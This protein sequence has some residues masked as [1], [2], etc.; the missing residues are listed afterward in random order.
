MKKRIIQKYRIGKI[1]LG[2]TESFAH[3]YDELAPNI[4][5][6]VFY[7]V[8]T[9]EEA[10]DITSQVFLKTWSY[11]KDE[12]EEIRSIKAF[13]YRIARN[14]IID[15]YRTRSQSVQVDVG[16]EM[17][18]KLSELMDD[19]MR[20]SIEHT[21]DM[22]MMYEILKELK[23]EYREIILLK[24]V[25]D[26]STREIGEIL[27]KNNNAVRTQLSRAMQSLKEL[28]S[29]NNDE[30]QSNSKNNKEAKKS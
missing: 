3:L 18:S 21:S 29:S 16:D 9:V 12:K 5:R 2:D 28:V 4:Y 7:K 15:Y 17:V 20:K 30:R 23:E 1:K 8:S 26:L 14:L 25:E 27:N 22:D 24:H 13:V 11:L 6:F 19:T 10:E